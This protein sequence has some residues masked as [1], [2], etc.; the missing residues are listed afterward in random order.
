MV[1]DDV[2]NTG[3]AINPVHESKSRKK[4]KYSDLG[5]IMAQCI[6]VVFV[7][8]GESLGLYVN[9]LLIV[10]E[11][12]CFNR[13]HMTVFIYNNYFDELSEIG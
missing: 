4:C 5:E 7:I 11:W 9:N 1:N 6:S 13:I 2:Y 8:M 12:S 3:Q 10:S